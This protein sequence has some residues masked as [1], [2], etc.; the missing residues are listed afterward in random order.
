M[1]ADLRR[2]VVIAA[3]FGSA[4]IATAQSATDGP[5]LGARRTLPTVAIKIWVPAGELRLVA[6]DRD[7][8]VVRGRT[9]PSGHF[10]FGGDSAGMKFGTERFGSSETGTVAHLVAYIPRRCT[11]SVKS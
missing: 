10:F 4:Q 3:M 5:V 1:R 7:S 6:W 8:V 11:V 2:T 9:K